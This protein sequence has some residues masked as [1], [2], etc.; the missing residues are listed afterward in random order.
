MDRNKKILIVDDDLDMLRLLNS[1]LRADGY[2][3]VSAQ[4]GVSCISEA[5]KE[6]PDLILLDLGL[7]AGDGFIALERLRGLLPLTG[8]PIVVLTGRS[9]EEARNR[10]MA[11]GAT[12]F[13]EK[14][15]QKETLL[16]AIGQLVNGGALASA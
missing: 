13:Y 14:S 2:E 11:A 5:R 1:Q 10:A 12:A 8:T 9:D 6:K 7:P 3:V 16:A 15:V 4:D